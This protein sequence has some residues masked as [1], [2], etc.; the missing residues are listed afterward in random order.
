MIRSRDDHRAVVQR[1]LGRE[2][3]AQQVGR[4]IAVDHHAGLRDLLEARLALDHDQGAVVFA[5][6]P[7]RRPS[8]L[9]GDHLRRAVLGRDEPAQ[10]ADAADAIQRPPQ[11]RLEHD[12]ERE[13]ADD[14]GGFKD[15][16]E[17]PEGSRRAAK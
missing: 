4:E 8:D 15:L 10:R 17:Q 11:L 9:G 16:G 3:R 13:Q 14:R 6:E 5:A 2:D 1:R 7:E 12:D